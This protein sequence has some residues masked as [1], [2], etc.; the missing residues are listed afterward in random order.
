[1]EENNFYIL[2]YVD[3]ILIA[4]KSKDNVKNVKAIL[5]FDERDDRQIR[6]G[7]GQDQDDTPEPRHIIDQARRTT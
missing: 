4:A 5:M 2:V 7:E 1:M 3:D 6:H